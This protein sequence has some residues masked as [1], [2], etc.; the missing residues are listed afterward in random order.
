M[1]QS[2]DDDRSILVTLRAPHR[3][4]IRVVHL[5][6]RRRV[7]YRMHMP[8]RA[9]HWTVDDVHALP[10]DGNRYE[11]IDGELFVTPAPA[12][13]TLFRDEHVPEYWIVD[14][15]ARTF[16]RTTPVDARPEVLA[17][18]LVWHPNG[19]SAPFTIELAEYFRRVLD[20]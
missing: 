8:Q 9:R 17:D 10:D 12:K 7:V 2:A 5:P 19:A 14:L 3:T 20:G 1:P 13:R 11:I 16:E 4:S 18:A 6:T 15:D